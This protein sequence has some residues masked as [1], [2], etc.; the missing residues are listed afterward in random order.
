MGLDTT[1]I[2]VIGAGAE[3]RRLRQQVGGTAARYRPPGRQR[4]GYPSRGRRP[5]RRPD[6]DRRLGLPRPPRS[7]PRQDT[8]PRHPLG[9]RPPRPPHRPPSRPPL[10]PHRPLARPHRPLAQ[11][12]D[13]R[14]YLQRSPTAHELHARPKGPLAT[15][16]RAAGHG[17]TP[18]RPAPP[19]QTPRRSLSAPAIG[20]HSRPQDATRMSA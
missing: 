17:S 18:A 6:R 4:T 19:G 20:V 1:G 9:P 7:P 8:R 10:C 12:P 15:P 14:R 16:G 3:I 13:D 11:P 2:Q 5:R